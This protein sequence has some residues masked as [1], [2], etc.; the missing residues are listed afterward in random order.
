MTTTK[1]KMTTKPTA[2]WDDLKTATGKRRFTHVTLPVCG[3]TFRVR[4]L[5]EREM[6]NHQAGVISA[7]G[8]KQY[9]QRLR[10][11]NRRFIALCLVDEEANP[12]VPDGEVGRLSELDSAD[13]SHLYTE[14]A[15]HVGISTDDLDALVGEAEKNLEETTES[16]SPTS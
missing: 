5:F 10:T 13:T 2:T 16:D 8:E 15:S 14:C 1:T 11:A 12:L 3:L 9:Q 6:S 7:R 4:S